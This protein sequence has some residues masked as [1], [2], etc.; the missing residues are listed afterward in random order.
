[1]WELYILG[2]MVRLCCHICVKDIVGSVGACV[3]LVC[4]RHVEHMVVYNQWTGLLDW[5]IFGF[6]TFLGG[7]IDSLVKKDPQETYTSLK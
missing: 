2:V 4:V 7:L 6:Y 3:Q 5:Y 1:M